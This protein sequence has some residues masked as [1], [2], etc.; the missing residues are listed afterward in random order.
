MNMKRSKR[1]LTG[2]YGISFEIE[3]PLNS[4]LIKIY[5]E[6]NRD[7]VS[8][9][10]IGKEYIPHIT[11]Y[12]FAAPIKNQK[13][14]AST[15]EKLYKKIKPKDLQI[16]SVEVGEN[17]WIL[18]VFERPNNI[19][20]Y[21]FEAMKLFNPLREGVLRKK[22]RNQRFFSQLTKLERSN[23]R[24]Y[25]DRHS[26][27]NY[28]PHISLACVESQSEAEEIVRKYKDRLIGRKVVISSLEVVRVIEGPNDRVINIF[29]KKVE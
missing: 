5:S 8:S 19:K 10:F 13:L 27:K 9:Y 11:L 16:K 15:A 29:S 1:L 28:E 17:R 25:G 7:Y 22:Y 3:E 2:T 23:L 21:H 4:E 14:M 26:I 24:K 6:I 18:T 20:K 12:F